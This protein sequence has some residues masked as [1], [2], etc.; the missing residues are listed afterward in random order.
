METVDLSRVFGNRD[1]HL[2]SVELLNLFELAHRETC[3]ARPPSVLTPRLLRDIIHR[4]LV[5]R[6]RENLAASGVEAD[7]RLHRVRYG[8]ERRTCCVVR[9]YMS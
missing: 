2:I 1:W 7:V 3:V 5:G 9:C 4:A 8:H 6:V